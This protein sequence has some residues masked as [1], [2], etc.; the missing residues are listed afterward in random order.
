MS[1][2]KASR[3]NTTPAV[4]IIPISPVAWPLSIVKQWLPHPDGDGAT[5]P[6]RGIRESNDEVLENETYFSKNPYDTDGRALFFQRSAISLWVRAPEVSRLISE[7]KAQAESDL[8][9]A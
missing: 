3:I 5:S 8:K 9:T 1:I 2:D 6:K 4:P 7:W